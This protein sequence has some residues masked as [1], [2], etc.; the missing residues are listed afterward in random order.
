MHESRRPWKLRGE[1]AGRSRLPTRRTTIHV[2]EPTDIRHA[3]SQPA[4]RRRH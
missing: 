4:D 2:D 3:N 1:G